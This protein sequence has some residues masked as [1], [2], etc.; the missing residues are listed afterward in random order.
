MNGTGPT[1]NVIAHYRCGLPE[2]FGV[3][4]QSGLVPELEGRVVFTPAYRSPESLRGLEGFSHLWLLWGFSE[5]APREKGWSPTVRPPRL[6]GNT[7]MGV[8]AT[9]SPNRPNPIGLSC[10]T[11][12]AVE[13][14][15]GL[16]LTLRVGGGDLTDGTPLYDIKP[17]LPFTDCRPEAKGGFADR[18]SGYA[19][20]VNVPDEIRA[21]R[22][23]SFWSAVCALLSED[24]RPSYQNDPERIYGMKYGGSEIRFRVE[25]GCASVVSVSDGDVPV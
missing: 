2:K 8:F 23:D 25:N 22:P 6:G 14:V 4:R 13:E 1:L 18:V 10:V 16:G 20:E 17:Y 21:T 12:L 19:L 5:N 7:R 9:R 24:P 15:S 3:P 11:L